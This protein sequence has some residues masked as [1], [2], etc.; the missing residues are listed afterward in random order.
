MRKWIKCCLWGGL[1][2]L[3]PLGILAKD[4]A[5]DKDSQAYVTCQIVEDGVTDD[6]PVINACLKEHPGRH[7]MLHKKGQASYGG[8]Q[9]SSKDIYSGQTLT[10]VGDA[11]WL[12][13]DVPALWA[14]GCRI[15]F[16]PKLEGP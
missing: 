7:V 12:D 9:A 8:G 6:G 16:S 13:C 4:T 11:Q 5:V 15:D 2:C 14:G 1:L 10:M 3:P